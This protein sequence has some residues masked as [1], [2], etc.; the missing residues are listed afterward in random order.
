MRAVMPAELVPDFERWSPQSWRRRPIVQDI[1]YEDGAELAAAV[2]RLRELP[3]LVTSGEIERLRSQ[4]DDAEKGR[5][6]VLQGGD[7]AETI[8]GCKPANITN[9]LK[10][11]LQMSLVLAHG[12]RRR[13]VRIGR[14]AGQYAKPRSSLIEVRGGETLPSYRGDLV[15]GA[16]FTENARRLD[17]E[18]LL[19]AYHHSALTLNFIRALADGGFADLHHPEYWDL[20]FAVNGT[21]PEV[22][23]RHY[24]EITRRIA[25]AIDL[26]E[27][28][29]ETSVERFSRA[30]FYTS[31]EGLH[32]E[33]AQTR[34]VPHRA[35]H[36]LLTTHMPWIGDRTRGLDGAHVEFFRGVRN[37]I[38]VKL[39]AS[40]TVDEVVALATLLNPRNEGGKLVFVTRLGAAQVL[41]KLPPLIEAVT[42]SGV[43]VLWMTDPMHGN[44]ITAKSGVKT[45]SFDDILAEIEMSFAVHARMGTILGGVHF[46]LTGEAVTECTGGALALSESDLPTN[47]TTA[48]H[49]RLNYAQALEMSFH[50]AQQLGRVRR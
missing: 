7:C 16:P 6:F 8:D 39:G 24:Q 12:G 25:D 45:R 48:C 49:P 5:R 43:R 13:V 50:I 44:T 28:V 35:G 18:R 27:T 20:S 9:K 33:S 47:Y 46:E 4:L 2:T 38:G 3:P 42:R 40:A 14:F 26:M 10:V 32:Y 41:A 29:G 34:T 22:L 37:P 15:N 31:H 19:A 30:D 11:L 21:L 36:F 23:R 1:S 17:P